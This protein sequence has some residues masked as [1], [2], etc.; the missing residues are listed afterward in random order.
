[1]LP[2][3]SSSTASRKPLGL[4]HSHTLGVACGTCSVLLYTYYTGMS[5]SLHRWHWSCDGG[6]TVVGRV[7]L[8]V[9]SHLSHL[10][11]FIGQCFYGSNTCFFFLHPPSVRLARSLFFARNTISHT[12]FCCPVALSFCVF[13][14]P[15]RSLRTQS[16]DENFFT[17]AATVSRGRG[18]RGR[19][20]YY[21]RARAH[22]LHAR[23]VSILLSRLSAR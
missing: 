16:S 19:T 9:P 8:C 1:M 4:S 15:S 18:R 2:P 17:T 13:F 3:H 11:V 5:F 21:A 14:P 23:S 7:K 10:L 12:P 6:D 20:T 22:I